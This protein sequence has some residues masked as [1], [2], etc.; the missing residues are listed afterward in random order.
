[1][2]DILVIL[3]VIN[4]GAWMVMFLF[5]P[6]F[7]RKEDGYQLFDSL[8]MISSLRCLQEKYYIPRFVI[9]CKIMKK[10]SYGVVVFVISGFSIVGYLNS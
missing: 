5:S 8:S 9:Y 6:M 7:Y 4:V 2:F 10:L 1:M 3:A